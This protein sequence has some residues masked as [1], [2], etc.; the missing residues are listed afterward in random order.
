MK[1]NH[2]W[3]V[4]FFAALIFS[5]G[6]D[7]ETSITRDGNILIIGDGTTELSL[8]TI[9]S[10]NSLVFS[11]VPMDS[12]FYGDELNSGNISTVILCDGEGYDVGMPEQGQQALLDFVSKGGR[13]IL[14]EWIAY[15]IE[16]DRYAMLDTIVPV[17]R[18]SGREGTE[19]Y[20]V[21]LFNE[22]T[23][24]LDTTFTVSSGS[25]IGTARFGTVHIK[26]SSSGDAL[27]THTWGQGEVIQM[28]C[29]GNYEGYNPFAEP[30]MKKLILNAIMISSL[31]KK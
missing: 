15:E 25:N 3:V 4:L 14:M 8:D 1:R 31:P 6:G 11:T 18:S 7:S 9:L 16:S 2:Y 5:C 21:Q 13:L 17:L 12:G 30:N 10:A 22:L 28:A 26:G 24:G 19:T 27:V 23:E 20:T 29:A